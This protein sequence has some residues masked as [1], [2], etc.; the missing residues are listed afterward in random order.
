M[1]CTPAI[2]QH[3]RRD[4]QRSGRIRHQGHGQALFSGSPIQ[5]QLTNS[6]HHF[7]IQ[8]LSVTLFKTCMNTN[9]DHDSGL[10]A[11]EKITLTSRDAIDQQL[12]AAER[13]CSY[14]VDF[15]EP[16]TR[17]A[18]NS[19]YILMTSSLPDRPL[20]RA[21]PVFIKLIETP[22][23]YSKVMPRIERR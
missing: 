4:N 21:F 23:L 17:R 1:W 13:T 11:M 12:S 15:A 9:L 18:S 7:F 22:S 20:I 5:H 10:Q 6:S 14:P 19:L 16:S 2:T 8:L 3:K